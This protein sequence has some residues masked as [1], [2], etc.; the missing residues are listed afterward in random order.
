[1]TCLWLL[2]VWHHEAVPDPWLR[3]DELRFCGVRFDLL[4]QVVD[5]NPQIIALIAIVGPPDR[6]Q[7]VPVWYWFA[8]LGYEVSQYL[9]FFGREMDVLTLDPDLSILEVDLQI[10]G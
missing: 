1:M 10:S 3:D 9:K 5:E 2:G 6:L 8:P 4:A 7:Q